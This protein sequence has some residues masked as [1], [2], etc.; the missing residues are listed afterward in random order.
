MR[1]A[2]SRRACSASGHGAFGC[3][4]WQGNVKIDVWH[5]WL[6]L[7]AGSHANYHAVSMQV[8]EQKSG[9]HIAAGVCGLPKCV[10]CM[11][12][13]CLH[14]STGRMCAYSTTQ[15]CALLSSKSQRQLGRCWHK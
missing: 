8:H 2:V 14:I 9:W 1:M 15:G 10:C 3:V 11:C 5:N 7:L 12:Y 4:P 6:C 13:I